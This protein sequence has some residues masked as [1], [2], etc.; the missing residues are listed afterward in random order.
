VHFSGRWGILKFYNP[1]QFVC[2]TK[3]AGI[4]NQSVDARQG[5]EFSTETI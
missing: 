1:G 5:P 4:F 3:G 2:Q